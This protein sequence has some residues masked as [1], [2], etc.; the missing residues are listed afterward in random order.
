MKYSDSDSWDDIVLSFEFK[1][2]AVEVE[3]KD[4]DKRVI[5]SLHQIM[6]SDQ[7]RR[8]TFGT[9]TKNAQMKIWFTCRV[10]PLVSKLLTS[11]WRQSTSS[12]SPAVSPSQALT[13][14]DGTPLCRVCVGGK[15]QYDINV[16]TDE[17]K[18][19]VY[20]TTSVISDFNASSLR[21]KGSS[22]F[23][24][25]SAAPLSDR[26]SIID[27]PPSDLQ[28]GLPTHVRGSKSSCLR[29]DRMPIKVCLV[30]MCILTGG[31]FSSLTVYA[32]CEPGPP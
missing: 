8:A 13:S 29:R 10:A 23:S 7:C 30:A 32:L 27:P 22:K 5:R 26:R 25:M 1:K 18:N 12:T 31:L 19:L 24:P 11:L 16:Y 15:I 9:T 4:Y 20:Q 14:L 3:R 2:I 21:G 17:G 6:R 28:G